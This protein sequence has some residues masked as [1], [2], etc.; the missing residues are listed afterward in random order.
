VLEALRDDL[1]GALGTT[2][3]DLVSRHEVLA[4]RRRVDR[5]LREGRLPFPVEGWPA[6]PWPPF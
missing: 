5:L 1:L 3:V 6:I 4:C 2:L